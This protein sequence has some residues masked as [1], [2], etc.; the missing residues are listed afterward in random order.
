MSKTVPFQTIQFSI[1]TQ[2]SFI[3][4]IERTLLGGTTQ[5]QS[6]PGSD[7]N[8]GVLRITQSSNIIGTL[9]SDCLV[10]YQGSLL[11]VVE[12]LTRL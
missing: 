12:S 5:G 7:G 8:E 2:F 3:W 6:E 10:S 1:S 4:P 11:L 9:T